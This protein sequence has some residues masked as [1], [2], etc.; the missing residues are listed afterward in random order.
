LQ[1]AIAT[2]CLSSSRGNFVLQ[3]TVNNNKL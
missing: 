3:L 1:V 2:G